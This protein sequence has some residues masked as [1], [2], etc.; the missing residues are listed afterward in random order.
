MASNILRL[1]F[2]NAAVPDRKVIF[3]FTHAKASPLETDVKALGTA[4]TNNKDIFYKGKPGELV[5]AEVIITTT[6]PINVAP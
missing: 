2:K 1:V 5:G 6:T 4:M 3:N